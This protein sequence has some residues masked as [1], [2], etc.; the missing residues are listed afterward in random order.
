MLL[1]PATLTT[2][3]YD[4]YNS[5][6]VDRQVLVSSMFKLLMI[7]YYNYILLVIM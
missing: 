2:A 1:S 3:N 6:Q 4:C 5:L 7:A